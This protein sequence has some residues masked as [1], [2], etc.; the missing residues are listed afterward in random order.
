MTTRDVARELGMSMHTLN[1]IES[2]G[3]I[4][5]GRKQAGTF[6]P[7]TIEHLLRLYEWRG[8]TFLGQHGQHGAGL[9]Y[10]WDTQRSA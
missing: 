5:Y 3:L 2:A 9:R 8:V 1:R 7:D 10:S 4:E 6:D